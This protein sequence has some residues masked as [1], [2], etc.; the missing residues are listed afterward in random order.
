MTGPVGRPG[1]GAAF[2]LCQ[3][4]ADR[5]TRFVELPGDCEAVDFRAIPLSCPTCQPGGLMLVR[6]TAAAFKGQIRTA[7][8]QRALLADFKQ[9][10]QS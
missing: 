8:E 6:A 5:L 3:D 9:R 2:E 10:R 4:C 7:D 1:S